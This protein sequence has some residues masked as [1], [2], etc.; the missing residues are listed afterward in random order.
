MLQ[1]IAR[2]AIAAPRRVIAVAL[3]VVVGAAVFGIPVVNSLSTG[4]FR[5][6]TSQSWHASQ[7]L[8]NKFG[9]GDMQLAL[10][11]TSDAGVASQSAHAAGDELVALL[12]S[13]P[14]VADVKSAWTVPP[15]AARALI[16]EDGKTGLVVAG[17]TGGE[18][19]A[20]QHAKDLLG[21][22]PRFDG[23]TVKPGD[24]VITYAQIIDQTKK[25]LLVMEAIA[26]PLS[27]MVLVWV[28]GGLLAAGLPLAV[29]IFAILGSMAVMRAITF[30]TEVSV[31]A[32][33]LILAMGL[34]L[35]VDYTLLIVSRF[36]DE[37]ADGAGRDQALV[38]TMTTAGRTVLFSATTVALAM[39]AM[40]LFPMYFLK[41]FA[42]AGIAVVAFAAAAA[43]VVTP[44]ALVLLGDRLDALDV[45]RVVR[46]VLGRPEPVHRP[47]DETFWYGWTKAIMGP[48]IPIGVA[49]IA[50]LLVL[51]A[52]FLG[53]KWGY[54]DDRVLP[55][56]ASARQVGDELRSG[57][58][59]NS[60][61]NVIVVIPDTGAVTA[62]EL[63]FYAAQLSRVPDVSAVSSPAGT[64][65]SGVLGGPP[66]A[67][68][69]WKDGSAY[70]TVNS[71]APLYSQASET[72]LDR[73]HAIA[74]PGNA[75]VQMTGWAQINRD[76]SHAVTSRLPI[77]LSVMATIT[78]LLLFLLTGSVI[79]PLKALALNMLSLTAAFGALVWI[80]QDGHLDGFGTTATGTLIASVPV[81]LFCLAFGLSMDYEVFLISRIGEYWQASGKTRADNTESVALGLARTG[82]VVTAAALLMAVTFSS[83]A[84]AK[85][86]LMCMFGVGVTLAVLV[87]ATLVRILLVPAFMRVLGRVN[88]WAPAPLVRLHRHIGIS[89][90]FELPDLS[91]SGSQHT[92]E[93]RAIEVSGSPLHE[94]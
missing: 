63:G 6:P 1:T 87:D 80:F 20:Q 86:S 26:F 57:F 64:Y 91:R 17:I 5:D 73:L 8:S 50:V 77:V 62:A 45:R 27:F 55:V 51:G 54:P 66:S 22:L 71:T 42:Y 28:F 37:L 84:A 9:A 94:R 31:F 67:P 59:V 89:E 41:S 70:L 76:S 23:V 30:A 53:V 3:L 14:Y 58:S 82:R 35:A 33:N 29:G 7:L 46:G 32:L 24:E 39:I 69:G 61:T 83:L 40:V 15:P 13:L 44:A 92:R 4:G 68:T 72:Q 47:V 56:S 81:L 75:T 19:G 18:T 11:V 21:S 65:A 43:V 88:W 78:F 25:D 85:V 36:R 38:R 60:L 49:V 93:A 16:S 10:A 34:A 79:L 74:T 48:A 90:Y 2:T 12:K 52:P